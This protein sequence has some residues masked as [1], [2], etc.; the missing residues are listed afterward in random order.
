MAR[1]YYGTYNSVKDNIIT[2]IQKSFEY[3]CDIATA[4]RSGNKFDLSALEPVRKISE[5]TT[6]ADRMLEQGGLDIRYQE[7]LR[8]H[9][10]REKHLHEN[11]KKTYSLIISNYCT[12]QM[13]TRIEEHPN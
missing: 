4:I 5:K 10:E 8:V 9:L 13:K 6:E 2:D 1:G 12:K 11:E 7:R 3:G